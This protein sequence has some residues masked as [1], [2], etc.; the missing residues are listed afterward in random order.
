MRL[1]DRRR[2]K[3]PRVPQDDHLIETI[4]ERIVGAGGTPERRTSE[5]AGVGIVEMVPVRK[6]VE[7][8]ISIPR[9][10]GIQAHRAF[11]VVKPPL[12]GPG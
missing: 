2:S 6:I 4:R 8:H 9:R 3:G 5:A 11:V 7:R 12:F 1:V 10:V